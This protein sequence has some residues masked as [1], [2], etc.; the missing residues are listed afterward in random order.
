MI[1][2]SWFTKPSE[3]DLPG[4]TRVKTITFDELQERYSIEFDTLVVDCEGALY[5]IL[6][7][8][9][10]IMKNIK[11]V[12]IENDGEVYEHLNYVFDLFAKNGLQVVYDSNGVNCGNG[13]YQVWKK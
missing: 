4:Y 1:Q 12:I 7:D 6:R 3:I 11:L 10:D 8:D 2:Q 13:F 9:P 5:Y